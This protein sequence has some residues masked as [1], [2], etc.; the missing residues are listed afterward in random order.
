MGV[1]IVFLGQHVSEAEAL[2]NLKEIRPTLRFTASSY[3]S[4]SSTILAL[5]LT[6]LS[7]SKDTDQRFKAYHYNRIR[8]IARFSAACFLGSVVLLLFMNLPF[9]TS[10]EELKGFYDTLYY[11]L[12]GY[13]SLLGGAVVII[14]ILL[15]QAA[16]DIILIAHPEEDREELYVSEKD[17]EEG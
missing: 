6:L 11:I 8:W 17:G 14:M 12:V 16:R 1:G 9:G 3:I 4:A 5:M 15:Y 2:E 10:R 13:T 7:F